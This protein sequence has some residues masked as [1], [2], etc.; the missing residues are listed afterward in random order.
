MS[1]QK[2]TSYFNLHTSGI[3][4]L[5]DVRIIDTKG[6]DIVACRIAALVGSSDKP[7]YRYFDMNAAGEETASLIRRC[8]DAVDA[9]KKV[10]VSFVM[11]DMWVETFTYKSDSQY[12]KK[13]DTGVSLKG[14]L[15]QV[16][17]IKIDGE[18]K[19]VKQSDPE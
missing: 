18:S 19:Y 6:G 13:G 2:Q 17:S 5:N 8:K 9:K 16:K 11:A 1:T 7:E 4:Y 14:R 10:L 3:G 15:I 12:H